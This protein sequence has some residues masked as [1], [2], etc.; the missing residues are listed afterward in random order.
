MPRISRNANLWNF[1]GGI[2]DW[3]GTGHRILQQIRAFEGRAYDT[4][5]QIGF[6]QALRT[7]NVTT[8]IPNA[9]QG[10]KILN[11]FAK[12]GLIDTIDN[13]NITQKGIDFLNA[14]TEQ[15]KRFSLRKAC[16]SMEFWNP[17]E[18]SMSH[19]FNVRP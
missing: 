4:D 5:T 18:T 17:V 2:S 7:A 6:M 13:I 19:N 15:E 10:R 3:L 12:V 9:I 1:P 11:S 8:A 16:E 14:N